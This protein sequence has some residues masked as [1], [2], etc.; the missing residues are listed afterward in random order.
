MEIGY[1]GKIIQLNEL[2]NLKIDDKFKIFKNNVDIEK[3][4]LAA[5]DQFK[6]L[7]IIMNG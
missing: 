6:Q 2:N 3:I 1:K 7:D 5:N 4:K